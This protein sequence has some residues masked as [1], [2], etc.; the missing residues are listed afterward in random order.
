MSTDS[1]KENIKLSKWSHCYT[2][3]EKKI[4]SPR[5]FIARYVEGSELF[6]CGNFLYN[7]YRD[8][9]DVNN[10]L[11]ADKICDVICLPLET[12]PE[13]VPILACQ[14]RVLRVLQVN[15][16]RHLSVVRN[17]TNTCMSRYMFFHC[18][19]CFIYPGEWI[20]L[21]GW[22]AWSTCGSTALRRY[23]W[24]VTNIYFD[25]NILYKIKTLLQ[26]KQYYS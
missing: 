19:S 25:K 6:T 13:I 9:K 21:W 26:M 16:W 15:M 5:L 10:Y 4:L 14:D 11:S 23:S 18:I 3:N 8:C 7:Q 12:N 22:D 1:W 2:N 17:C 20:T 24:L